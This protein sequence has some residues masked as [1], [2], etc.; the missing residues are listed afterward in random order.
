[1]LGKALERPWHPVSELI[2]PAMIRLALALP[3]AFETQLRDQSRHFE[4]QSGDGFL[5]TAEG[6][7][8]TQWIYTADEGACGTSGDGNSR[9]E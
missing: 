8:S 1:M 2:L 3:R 9:L 4:Y 5:S 7:I 6:A